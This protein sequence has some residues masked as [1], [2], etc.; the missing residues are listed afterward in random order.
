MK[1]R[2]LYY[3]LMMAA[4]V[5]ISC[6]KNNDRPSPG[7]GKDLVLT[8]EEQQQ[9]LADNAFNFK[10][11]KNLAADPKLNRNLIFSPL[12]I[13]MALSMTGNGASGSTLE[14]MRKVLEQKAFTEEQINSYHKKLNT[15]LPQLDPLADL[16][17][18]NSIWYRQGFT[19]L[20]AFIDL[21]KNNYNAAVESL[22][23]N[24]P[25]A[26]DRINGWVAKNTKDKIP[27]I[28]D[29][30]G[31]DIV[32]YLINAVY[33][34]SDWKYPFDKNKTR[35][36]TFYTNE[37]KS[38]QAD[39]MQGK[40]TVKTGVFNGV[41]VAELPY[42]NEKYSMLLLLPEE[43]KSIMDVVNGTDTTTWNSWMKGLRPSTVELHFPKFKF[44]FKTKLNT[45]LIDLG[46][47][48]PFSNSADF[49][50][51]NQGGGLLISEVLH[52]AFIEVNETGTEAAAVTSVSMELTAIIPGTAVFIVDRPFIFVIRE[53]KTGLILFN[54][55][56]RN[57]LLAE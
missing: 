34:K 42:G 50:R 31:S 29:N 1:T 43:G 25:A 55:I 26:K 48:I 45:P 10:M 41:R 21:N 4:V 5:F 49:S 57:P 36:E 11:F 6:K 37:N 27:T 33:F 38:I 3:G 7:K 35:K 51:I 24:N 8:A 15:E 23:F 32:M 13:S 40:V 2:H 19:P 47:P 22:D 28:L 30:I 14:Q 20:P 53:M 9:V 46:M 18:A 17:L 39:F 54:G 44:A 52:K 56:V 16:Q 12:S